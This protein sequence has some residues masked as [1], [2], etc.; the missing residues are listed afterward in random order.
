MIM[1]MLSCKA[2]A[3]NSL[4]KN[5]CVGCMIS[6]PNRQFQRS[7]SM[8]FINKIVGFQCQ[9]QTKNNIYLIAVC[10]LKFQIYKQIQIQKCHR[11]RQLLLIWE[12]GGADKT[13]LKIELNDL[14][15]SLFSSHRYICTRGVARQIAVLKSFFNTL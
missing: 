11:K 8:S 1:P 2:F 13:S 12:V 9:I 10:Y 4:K 15:E 5:F 14:E 3:T 6:Q 7:T